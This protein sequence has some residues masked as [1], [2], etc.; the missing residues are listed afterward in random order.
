MI[1]KSPMKD[2]KSYSRKYHFLLLKFYLMT[3]TEKLVLKNISDCS[4]NYYFL[5]FIKHFVK[6]TNF[7]LFISVCLLTFEI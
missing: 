3:L 1:Q 6:I 2:K 5:N 7:R 4:R